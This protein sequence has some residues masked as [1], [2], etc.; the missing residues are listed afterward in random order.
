MDLAFDEAERE[1]LANIQKLDERLKRGRRYNKVPADS[2]G[3]YSGVS[4][5]SSRSESSVRSEP[6]MFSPAPYPVMM[7]VPYTSHHVPSNMYNPFSYH[8]PPPI[9]FNPYSVP[10]EKNS[11][12]IF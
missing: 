10:G 1:I 3:R 8:A 7:S 5:Q 11:P 9:A 6:I 4:L 12:L 2:D